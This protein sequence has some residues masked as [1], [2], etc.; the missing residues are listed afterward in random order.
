MPD[1]K[2]FSVVCDIME[3][4]EVDDSIHG[5]QIISQSCT[6][7]PNSNFLGYVCS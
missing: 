5:T 1:N 4:C 3:Q 2:E 6:H 7:T